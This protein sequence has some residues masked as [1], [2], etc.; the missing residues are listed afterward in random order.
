MENDYISRQDAILAIQLHGIGCF[1]PDDFIPEQSERYVI[2]LLESLPSA[3]P[4]IIRCKDCKWFDTEWFRPMGE[5]ICNYLDNISVEDDYFCA[6]A[7]KR[8]EKMDK[9]KSCPFCGET[10]VVH[11]PIDATY[12]IECINSGC[13][14]L[15]ETW[16]YD[17]EEEAIEAW[18]R[19]AE[20]GTAN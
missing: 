14:C 19:R 20:D 7:R 10:P 8:E 6:W 17:T 3:Q 13:S 18:N 4:E 2:N 11:H 16:Y 15:P 9:L 1:D 5:K 12:Y